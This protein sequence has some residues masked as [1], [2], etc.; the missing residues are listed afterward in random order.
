MHILLA[1]VLAA[2]MPAV[3]PEIWP[4]V[5]QAIPR[6]AALERRIDGLLSRMTLEQKVG[7]VIQ[8]SITTITPAD[9]RNYHLGS[10]L[11]GGGGWPGDVRKAAPKDWLAM[12]D[13]FYE[14][15]MDTSGGR[16]AIPVMW[17]SDAVH[18]HNNIVGAT[19]FPHNVGLGAMRNPDLIR[20]IGE[21]T[22]VEMRATG[23]DWNFSP[24]VAVA[25]DDRWGRAYESWSEEPEVVRAYAEKMIEGLQGKP[26][27]PGFLGRGKVIA[28]AKHFLGD[29]GTEGGRDQGNT[30]AT[31]V[32]LR[33][34]HGA[35][36]VGALRAGVQVVMA[37]YNSWHGQKLHGVRELLTDVLKTRMGFDGLVVGDWNGHGQVAGCTNASCPQSFNAGVDI[38]MVPEDWKKLYENTIA[39]VKSGE[40]S[41]E[42]LDDAVRRIL[43]VKYRAGLFTAGKPSQ[44]PHGG[45]FSVIG[46][47][48]HRAVARQAVRES[49]VLLK[50]NGGLLPVR[51]NRNVLIAGDGAD[52]IAKQS[53]GWTLT[54]QGDGNTNADFPGGTSI[55]AGIRSAVQAAGGRATISADGTFTQKP[56]V[57]IVVFGEDPYAEFQGDRATV[58]YEGDDDL[59]LL[60]KLKDAGIPV[61]SVFL[62]GRPLWVNPHLNASDAFVAAWL[63][64]TEGNGVAD[65]LIAG[66]DGK[67]RHDFK[68]KLSFSWPKLPSQ[69][70]LNRGGANY[71]PLFPYG[72]GLTYSDRNDLPQLTVDMTGVDQ[73]RPDVY[74]VDGRPAGSWTLEGSTL[75]GGPIDLSRESNGNLALAVKLMLRAAPAG[76]VRMHAGSG[77]V[78]ITSMLRA[79][80]LNEWQTIRVRLRCFQDAGADMTRIDGFALTNDAQ[81]RLDDM[82][83]VPVADQVC[84]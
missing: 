25:R 36:Y 46:S 55:G 51:G 50:N 68:G 61:V 80:P 58:I 22:A 20:R 77:S 4:E 11:N 37:S 63:P 64:G 62:S 23:I 24:T 1:L 75:R 27:S 6:D 67:A 33:D 32:E 26:R 31:E 53:G 21:V 14:A 28:T 7:Q 8:P 34:I 65:V 69:S 29:G 49:L 12:A 44:R 73:S 38:F 35:G 48:A 60:R 16:L 17:G 71:D 81:L 9:V 57:A 5:P 45:D 70:V 19:L 66:A 2:Q 42:R 76:P 78:D 30:L 54:W 41:R 3:H 84:P 39:Q 59:A 79:L 83:L 40:I 72:F 10:V 74:L 56:D 82:R 52:S 15:S 47:P 18:G 13:A 43:R